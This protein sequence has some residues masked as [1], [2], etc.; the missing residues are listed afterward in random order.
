[1]LIVADDLT[2]AADSAGAFAAAGHRATVLI[3]RTS[4]ASDDPDEVLAIDTDGRAVDV[5][6]AIRRTVDAVRTGPPGPVFVKIDST[7]RGHVGATVM[8]ALGALASPPE[9]IVVCPAFPRLGRTVVDEHVHVGSVPIEAG[10]LRD[11]LRDLSPATARADTD[12]E[13]DVVVPDA[14]SDDDLARVVR[15]LHDP[16][17]PGRTLWVGSAGLAHELARVTAPTGRMVLERAPADRVAVVVG[18]L[19]DASAA[20]L[21]ELDA[22][23]AAAQVAVYR[24]DP[25]DHDAVFQ[26]ASTALIGVDGLVLTGGATARAVLDALGVDR[27]A[28]GGEVETGVPWSVAGCPGW[29]PR[30]CSL[31]TKAGGFGDAGALRRAV[32]FLRGEAQ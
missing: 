14:V 9:R 5:D 8:A 17:H 26:L 3:G 12:V 11:A 31:V 6:E 24:I 30:R 1:M 28:V 27:F 2:G 15:T 7:L 13:I 29:N 25:R 20:Q 32:Q 4:S 23:P 22:G 10:S 16:R 21:D 19:H 18:S